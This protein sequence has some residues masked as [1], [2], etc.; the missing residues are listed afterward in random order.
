MEVCLVTH[1]TTSYMNTSAML[2]SEYYHDLNHPQEALSP[3]C[4]N[5]QVVVKHRIYKI[6]LTVNKCIRDETFRQLQRKSTPT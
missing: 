2:N 5:Q 4:G 1:V 3:A 6:Y